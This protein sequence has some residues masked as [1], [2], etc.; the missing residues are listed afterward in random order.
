MDPFLDQGDDEVIVLVE[1]TPIPEWFNLELD[2]IYD[3]L[4]PG[5][6]EGIAQT[7][8]WRKRTNK[9]CFSCVLIYWKTTRSI[10]APCH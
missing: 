1:E 7:R 10:A 6:K 3:Q 2:S 5:T 9:D 8:A 4:N